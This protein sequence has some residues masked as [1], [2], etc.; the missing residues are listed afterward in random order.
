MCL[1]VLGCVYLCQFVCLALCLQRWVCDLVVG[2]SECVFVCLQAAI[3]LWALSVCW[4]RLDLQDGD[5]YQADHSRV[6]V[7]GPEHLCQGV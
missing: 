4:I 7:C 5:L 1:A 3:G 2:V 6:C